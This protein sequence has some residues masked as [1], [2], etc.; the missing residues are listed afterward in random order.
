VKDDGP[1]HP[2]TVDFLR[3]GA[4]GE[5]PV[6]PNGF[7]P[8]LELMAV[9]ANRDNDLGRYWRA[10]AGPGGTPGVIEGITPGA[11]FFRRGDPNADGVIDISD[12]VF[13]LLYL[14]GDGLE[15]LC[16]ESADGNSSG[17]LNAADPL[18]ILNYLFMNGAAPPSPFTNCGPE[19][20]GN[21]LS[22]VSY[23]PCL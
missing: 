23:P 16:L 1:G 3:Y 7:G 21:T 8:S 18:H 4:S 14:F 5:W 15:P 17:D 20:S 11:I 6:E 9:D 13:L 2:A 19:N 10:S 22:C 12:G